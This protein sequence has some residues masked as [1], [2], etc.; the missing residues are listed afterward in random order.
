MRSDRKCR[1][2]TTVERFDA[3]EW[4]AEQLDKLFSEGFPVF[5]T[6]DQLAKR[7]IGRVQEWFA[8]LNIV[9]LDESGFLV[10][11]GWGVPLVWNGQTDSLPR[12]YS[13]SLKRA[14]EGHE[15]N[16]TPNTFVICGGIVRPDLKGQGLS[17]VLIQ[18]LRSLALASDLAQVICPVRPTLKSRYPLT[19]IEKYMQWTR[20]DGSPFDPWVR[21]HVRAGAKILTTEP[22]S[23]TMTGTVEQ[24]EAWTGLRFPETGEYVIPDGMSLLNIDRESDSG[25]YIEPN[26]WV[27]HS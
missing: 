16:E 20:A 22:S 17:T 8:N 14:V 21:T 25:I 27:Q 12:G 9:L 13:E 24:W 26:V 15:T 23:Q 19:S 7:Y 6:S 10:A 2:R 1:I 3:R 18:T 5:I 11:A 4:P